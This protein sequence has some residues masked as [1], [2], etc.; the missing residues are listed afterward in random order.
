MTKTSE[1]LSSIRGRVL[2][3]DDDPVVSGMLCVTL[4]AAGHI[5]VEK[6]SA[7]AALTYLEGKEKEALPEV[8]FADIEMPGVNGYDLC[9]KIRASARTASIPVVFI[10]SHDSL[11]DRIAAY[12]AGGDDFMSKPFD[13]QEVLK[14]AAICIR[15]RRKAL[16]SENLRQSAET[17]AMNAMTNLGETA[18]QLKYMRRILGCQSLP[19]LVKETMET[20][21]E[22]GLKGLVQLRTPNQT[23]TLTEHGPASPLEESVFEK[24]VGM[25]RVFSFKNRMIVNHEKL[26]ILV[27]NMPVDDPNYAG[28]IRDHLA[29]IAESGNLAADN[30]R[31]RLGIV[32]RAQEMNEIAA[33]TSDTVDELRT[34]YRDIQ[35]SAR[36]ELETMTNTIEGMYVGL[37]LTENQE[38]TVSDVVRNATEQVLNRLELSTRLD[39]SFEK[40]VSQL[41][42]S[43]N[44]DFATP[45]V[46]VAEDT[47]QAIELW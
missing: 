2:V 31:V 44:V 41:S 32:S 36:M 8:I 43:A 47:Y 6:D 27:V 17:V 26:S 12:E 25:G 22:F 3:I 18:I 24:M 15:H 7:E 42:Y 38:M 37:G 46:S 23:I 5:G 19:A 9:R 29:I 30:I 34:S 45:A 16:L 10:S 28:R 1:D 14:K 33:V 4:E 21:S 35:M 11:D 13:P 39:A 40:I 20:T